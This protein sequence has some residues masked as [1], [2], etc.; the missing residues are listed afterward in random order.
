M[1]GA[2]RIWA[3]EAGESLAQFTAQLSEAAPV[4]GDMDPSHYPALFEQLISTLVVRPKWGSHP[5]VFLWGPI[6][7]RL[8]R[9]DI[10]VLGGL[11][12]GTWP[13]QPPAATL[14][15]PVIQGDTMLPPG[16][17]LRP[18][19]RKVDLGRRSCSNV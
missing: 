11:N 10:M 14:A 19:G 12:E 9:A 7:A 15:R 6:E 18:V 16:L 5:R 1:P 17:I 4:L 2:L 3:E 8:Q 13:P